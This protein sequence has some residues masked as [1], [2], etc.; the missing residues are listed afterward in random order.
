V[1]V[2]VQPDSGTTVVLMGPQVYTAV[3]TAMSTLCGSIPALCDL[4]ANNCVA[5]SALPD[6]SV[7]PTINFHVPDLHAPGQ[8]FA[9]SLPPASYAAAQGADVCLLIAPTPSI[10]VILGATAMSNY[11]IHHDRKNKRLGF[12]PLASCE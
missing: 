12:A 2:H 6:V 5:A 10:G 1:F 9:V 7:L 3:T 4:L 8:T 11:Y